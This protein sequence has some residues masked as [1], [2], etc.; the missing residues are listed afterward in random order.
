L[1]FADHAPMPFPG[2]Y[3]SGFRM[4]LDEI[5]DY[6]GTLRALQKEYQKDIRILIGFEAEYYPAVFDDF[7]TYIA[8][9]HLDYLIMGQ[10]ALYNEEGA[11]MCSTPTDD[12]RLLHQ[13]VSQ[14]KEGLS[15]GKFLYHAHPDM[16]RFIGD[17]A[18]YEQ[19][20]TDYC[21]FCLERGI[22]LEINLLGIMDNRWYP[23]SDF[24]TIASRVG[25]QAIIGCDAHSPGV[26]SDLALHKRG[27]EWAERHQVPLIQYLFV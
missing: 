7:L 21:R 4:K 9:Y 12:P 19:E 20:M 24:W 13:Y 2:A 8:P 10:H 27:E 25:N 1:G 18:I 14:V 16:M 17:S 3:Y 15:T 22:P 6:V 26:L 23:R 11:P 5:D